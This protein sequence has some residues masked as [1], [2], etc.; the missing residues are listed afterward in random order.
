[1]KI[2]LKF[3]VI[4]CFVLTVAFLCFSCTP[5]E[6]D[7]TLDQLRLLLK[8]EKLTSQTR[9][10]VLNRIANSLYSSK[11]SGEMV[12]FL[13]DWVEKNPSDIY[14]AYW[15]L[16]VASSYL[17]REAEPVAEY[18]FNRILKNYPDLLVQGK[19]VHFICL[20]HLIQISS[21]S[22]NKISYFNQLI[23]RCPSM[24]S[25]TTIG[26]LQR[27]MILKPNCGSI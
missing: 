17:E 6:K 21:S 12:L 24:V 20:Q 16:M 27:S 22:A 10:A 2:K 11:N 26:Q 13:T 1:M 5:P 18:Y 8:D 15:L 4:L 23:N 19:S 3:F 9:Y 25:I 7:E 14:N